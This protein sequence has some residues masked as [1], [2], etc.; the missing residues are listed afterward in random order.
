MTLEPRAYGA[1]PLWRPFYR[2]LWPFQYFRDVTRG[3]RVECQR[4]YRHNR[5][6]RAY[7]PG[8]AAKWSVLTLLWC[9]AGGVLDQAAALVIPAACCFMT[10]TCTLSVV[11]LLLVSWVWLER[12]PELY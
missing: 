12:F 2:Y 1:E 10:A 11:V 3:S 5:S 8:F 6:M 9:V 4:N 7:L